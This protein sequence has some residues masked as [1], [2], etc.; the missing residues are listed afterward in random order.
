MDLSRS[1]QCSDLLLSH[2]KDKCELMYVSG[3]LPVT[4]NFDF[5]AARLTRGAY[6]YLLA[7]LNSSRNIVECGTSFGVS[8]IYLALAVSKNVSHRRTDAYGVLTI[9]KD[10][11]K[12]AKAK[13]IWAEAGPEVG[14]WIQSREGDLLDILAADTGLPEKVDMVF[15]DG[16]RLPNATF[17]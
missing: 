6:R 12:V 13:D 17:T 11:R 8:A 16:K 2:S 9:E 14:G 4:M 3:L 7:C 10:G 15:L 5:P 1:R